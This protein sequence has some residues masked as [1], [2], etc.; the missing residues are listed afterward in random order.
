MKPLLFFLLIFLVK[1]ARAENC[2]FLPE[3]NVSIP[4]TVKN[5]GITED[6][7]HAVIDKVEQI[8]SPIIERMGYGLKIN[9]PWEH[10]RVNAGTLKDGKTWIINLYG[11]FARHKE[12]TQDGFALVICHEIG[13]HIGGAPKKSSTRW[14][15]AEGQADYFATL[16]CL[17]KVFF[18]DD[19]L[20]A[21][22]NKPYPEFIKEKCSQTFST[23]NELA[24]C[25][26]STIAGLSASRVSAD[27]RQVLPTNINTPD[28]SIVKEV[29]EK[30]PKPQCRLDTYFQGAICGV[31]ASELLSP[32]RPE[33]GTCHPLNKH[34]IGLRPQCWFSYKDHDED[35]F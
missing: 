11:G 4:S 2:T 35:L 18:T 22:N 3:N 29:Y 1:L 26:R 14:S 32:K 25:I 20:Q 31:D 7:Y 34:E 12:I 27:I 8:Y 9:R 21:I 30:H 24:L 19:N 6:E 10:P 33:L 23:P 28:L 15:S 13:H 5:Q 17:R 16:K